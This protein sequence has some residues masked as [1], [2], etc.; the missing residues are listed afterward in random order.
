[1]VKLNVSIVIATVTV[2]SSIADATLLVTVE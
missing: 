1:M 2:L